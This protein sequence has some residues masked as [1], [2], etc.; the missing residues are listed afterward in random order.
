MSSEENKLQGR[1]RGFNFPNLFN[2]K[3]GLKF[4]FLLTGLGLSLVQ[5]LFLHSS[6]RRINVGYH[7]SKIQHSKPFKILG[8]SSEI[9]Q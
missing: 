5:T 9:D 8:Q 2:S 3:L 6:L 4:V 1:M 7:L